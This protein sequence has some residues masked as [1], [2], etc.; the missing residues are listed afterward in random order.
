MSAWWVLGFLLAQRAVEL[1]LCRRNRR[2]LA[3]RGGKEWHPE[4][5]PAMV[6]L[7]ALFLLSLAVES[8]PWQVPL[9][10]RTLACLAALVP[11]TL[12]RYWSI[13]ALGEYWTT[14]I[15][16]VPGSR[17]VRAGPYRFLRHP[18]YL[19]VVLEFVLFPLLLRAPYTLAAFS[20]ANLGVLRAR[21]R[22]E[23]GILAEQTDYGERRS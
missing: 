13:A 17:A 6:A 19:A 3:L 2:R 23:E 14:R 4:T 9:D 10:R 5:Y 11:V 15:V 18:N 7:H 22:R 21:I 20:L 16:V 8:Y 1:A 12:L